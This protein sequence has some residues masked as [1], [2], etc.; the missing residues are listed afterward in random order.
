MSGSGKTF[1]AN[2]LT[3]I[4]AQAGIILDGKCGKVVHEP[5][6]NNME[7]Y[8]RQ[9]YQARE[10]IIVDEAYSKKD[11]LIDAVCNMIDTYKGLRYTIATDYTKNCFLRKNDELKQHFTHMIS[12]T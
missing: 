11:E 1:V 7:E 2:I 9:L 5:K 6:Y 12:T 4:F 8:T 10:I 3:E